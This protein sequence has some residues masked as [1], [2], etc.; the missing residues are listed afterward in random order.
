MDCMPKGKKLEDLS[1]EEMLALIPLAAEE[2]RRKQERLVRATQKL[3]EKESRGLSDF[4]TLAH[5]AQDKG[6]RWNDK[7]K[8]PV[9][10]STAREKLVGWQT[11]YEAGRAQTDFSSLTKG[12][13][14]TMSKA[15]ATGLCEAL[16]AFLGVEPP[17]PYLKTRYRSLIGKYKERAGT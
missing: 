12:D 3:A 9:K 1:V 17:S 2:V 16:E 4:W 8:I 11:D 13:F 15:Y 6:F 14:K 10:Y 7:D 5:K